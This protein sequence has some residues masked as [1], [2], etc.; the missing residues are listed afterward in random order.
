MSSNKRL[1]GFTFVEMITTVLIVAVLA[2][3]AM[4]MLQVSVKRNKENLLRAQLREIRDAI[5][6]YKK[7]SDEGRIKKTIEASG[8]PVSLLELVDGVEDQKDPKRKRIKFLRRIPIDPMY[9]SKADVVDA[10]GVGLGQSMWGL[11]SYQ[12]SADKPSYE[13]D[14]YDVYSLSQG[15]GMNGVPYAQW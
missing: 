12:S 5:D 10:S 1:C 9:K 8:Y 13:G 2:S 4:P 14:V 3:I 15:I 6:A 7:A 11:R